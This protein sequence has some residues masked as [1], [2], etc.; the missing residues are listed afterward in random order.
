M[1]AGP[2]R[3]VEYLLEGRLCRASAWRIRM[4]VGAIVETAEEDGFRS[5][6]VCLEKLQVSGSF[7]EI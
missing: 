1:D 5:D 6:W 3:A 2:L 4:I 7:Y